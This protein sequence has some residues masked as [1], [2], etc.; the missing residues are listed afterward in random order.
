[1]ITVFRDIWEKLTPNYTTP[2][3]VVERIRTGKDIDRINI[4][5]A[6]PDTAKRREL[7]KRLPC[8]CWTGKFTSRFDD[9]LIEH[10]GLCCLDIDHID[11]LEERKAEISAF[12][13]VY[14][15]FISPS[16]DGLKVIARIP[17]DIKKHRGYYEGLM[18]IFPQLDTSSINESRVCY[19]SVDGNIYFNPNATEFT[20]FIDTTKPNSEQPRY[21]STSAKTEWIKIGVGANMIRQAMNGQ[22]HIT[23][24]KAAKLMG[25]YIAGGMVNETDAIQMLEAEISK[26]EIDDF[27][28][29]QK[30][31]EAGIE[32][33][34]KTPLTEI[35][36]E[37]FKKPKGTDAGIKKVDEVWEDMKR[38]FVHGKK[39]G[40]TTHFKKFDENFKWKEGEITL[41]I[42]RPNAGKT[43]FALQ[44][45][46]MKS[47]FDKWKWGVFSPENYPPDEFYDTMI[48]AYIGK[49][50]DPFYGN[51]QMSL[52]DYERG[53]K[54]VREHFY[55]VYPDEHTIEHIDSNFIYLIE[56]VGIK[57]TL[58]DP[59]NQIE[60][61]YG[62]RQDLFLS[63][64]L[65]TRK[66]ISIKYGLCDIITTH[67]KSMSRNKSGEYDIPDMYDIAG[68][69]MWGNKMDNIM[70]LHR[71]HFLTDPMN[72][73]VEVH[74]RKIKKQKL[75]GIPGCCTFTF[76]RKTNRYYTDDMNPLEE[77]PKE[78]N[79]VKRLFESRS[80]KKEEEELNG[81][82]GNPNDPF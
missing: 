72:T 10:S 8:I 79:I 59:F 28:A 42:A 60:A 30:T 1:M 41:I 71:P 78:T 70:V 68:G 51:A 67:P 47:V 22:K 38:T 61:D 49:T 62:A 65:T 44:L 55:Y 29:A 26:H 27:K 76:Q 14:A 32:Y 7:K 63:A 73:T 75:V 4:V 50:P 31:I 19:S 40:S 23:L 13:F 82:Y 37:V 53:Y 25:G 69:A 81:S 18:K 45:M 74:V 58:L 48:H 64:F 11:S 20:D 16:G 17:A 21:V 54:F 5:R 9:K 39:R 34:K 66:R 57:G 46:L 80:A 2:E 12:P 15:C 3:K 33:G 24:L 56:E 6:E 35:E 43:E 36:Q 77:K 52:E